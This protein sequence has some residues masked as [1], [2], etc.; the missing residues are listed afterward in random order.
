MIKGCFNCR[1]KDNSAYEEPCNS[2]LGLLNP[3][4]WEWAL[5]VETAPR[6]RGHWIPQ[7][8][9]CEYRCSLCGK[10]IF[11][12]DSNEMNYCCSCGARM[13]GD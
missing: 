6:K 9:E 1:Y 4:K 2:C 5:S 12:D 8:A 7:D 13:E 3:N 10:I 11:A